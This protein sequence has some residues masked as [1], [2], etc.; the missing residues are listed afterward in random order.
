MSWLRLA[1]FCCCSVLT[2]CG[3]DPGGG[4]SQSD[5]AVDGGICAD[6]TRQASDF[7]T[8]HQSCNVDGDCT[9]MAAYGFI[10]DMGSQVSCWPPVLISTDAVSGFTAVMEQMFAARCTGPSLICSAYEPVAACTQH[11]CV[12]K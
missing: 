10:Y 4:A 8:T 7:V 6:L 3:A 11:V 9:G 5:A 1:L 12:K 2:G